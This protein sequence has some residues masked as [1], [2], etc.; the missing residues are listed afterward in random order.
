MDLGTGDGRFVLASAA[1]E[2]ETLVIGIDASAGAMAESSDRA[3]RSPRRGGL[4][5]AM[6]VAAA[7]E[8]P[9]AELLGIASRVVIQ[10]PW[11]SLLRGA[12]ALDEDVARG[13]RVAL[14]E[15][16]GCDAALLHS[17]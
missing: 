13:K 11:G 4:P 9:P 8:T 2:P 14:L 5:N 6:F 7:A 3:A 17:R 15:L 10:L 12:L 16:P 1:A